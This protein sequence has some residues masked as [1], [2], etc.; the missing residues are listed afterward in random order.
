MAV[1]AVIELCATWWI[2]YSEI[3]RQKNTGNWRVFCET[4]LIWWSIFLILSLQ[5]FLMPSHEY[6]RTTGQRF[7]YT[8]AYDQGEYFI[9]RDGRMKKSVPD[10]EVV[11]LSHDEAKASLMLRMA[12]SDIELLNGMNE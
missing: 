3:T 9:E 6:K 2:F 1:A 5:G 8:I 4:A 10:A 12:I 7:S 11:G